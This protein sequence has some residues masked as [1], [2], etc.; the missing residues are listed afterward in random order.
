M[1]NLH[2]IWDSGRDRERIALRIAAGMARVEREEGCLVVAV[3]VV[4]MAEIVRDRWAS[5][6]AGMSRY[7]S[8]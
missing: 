6:Q 3:P 4:A 1:S 5:V 8:G 7:S 2:R